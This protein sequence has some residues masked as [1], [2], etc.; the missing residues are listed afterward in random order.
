MKNL[1]R[2]YRKSALRGGTSIAV[3][4]SLATASV[5]AQ[6]QEQDQESS[7][8]SDQVIVLDQIVVSA[9]RVSE[10]LQEVPLAITALSGDD[11][12]RQQVNDIRDLQGLV[13]NLHL[14]NTA[15]T[16][17]AAA[18]FIR[19]IGQP[20]Q[21]YSFDPGVAVYVDE[22]YSA[23]LQLGLVQAL[24]IERVEVLRGPQGTLYGKNTTGGAIKFYTRQPSDSLEGSTS[25]SAGNYDRLDL[26]GML[27]VPLGEGAAL[28]A[29][30][31]Y[32]RRDGYYF[33]RFSNE[34]SGGI[35]SF[36]GRAALSFQPTENLDVNL[37]LDHTRDRSESVFGT[38]LLS[39]PPFPTL[40]P[41]EADA[42]HPSLNSQ[43]ST[44]VSAT[45]TLALNAVTLKS[46]SGYRQLE[47]AQN[48]DLDG[49][50]IAILE[51][52]QRQKS[53]QFSQELQA[54]FDIGDRGNAILGAYYFRERSQQTTDTFG[55]V[56]HNSTDQTT[57]SL[58]AFVNVKYALT[59]QLT[60]SGGIRF[61]EESKDWVNDLPPYLNQ[62]HT[63][64]SWTNW[65]SRFALDYQFSPD[66]LGYVSYADGFKAGGFNPQ[67]IGGSAQR[68][69]YDPE[70]VRSYELG[71]KSQP[72]PWLTINTALFYNDFEDYQALVT[73]IDPFFSEL[74]GGIPI[75]TTTNA[76][77]FESHGAEIEVYARPSQ[78]LTLSGNLAYFE[79]SYSDFNDPGTGADLSSN[80]LPNAPRWQS[81]L[82][83]E[84][85][86]PVGNDA[87]IRFGGTVAYRSNYYLSV[88]NDSL[89]NQDGYARV[90]AHI[91]FDLNDAVTFT[92]AGRNLTE[93]A[94]LVDA[95][96]L[97]PLYVTGYYGE[98]RVVSISA[99]A[100][101]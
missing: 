8:T 78:R 97:R 9:R 79:N 3:M 74:L 41:F 60:A 59:D 70:T 7:A 42:N 46:I 15:G 4:L 71:I 100:R 30:A 68:P 25:I 24:D 86:L 85:T 39:F 38:P 87:R 5:F 28:R 27:N 29:N 57:E 69:S 34:D 61:S 83:A 40:P 58:A 37:S 75:G 44:G 2:G 96:G 16:N 22:V 93:E 49:F 45:A 88:I 77:G 1:D 64:D 13:P 90:D 43:D 52:E 81:G 17:N 35:D 62:F 63:S 95:F 23:R 54:L 55:Q 48:L 21:L 80:K 20:N 98:P 6:E 50:P 92:L 33:N 73:V 36:T 31:F 18:V 32:T 65:T 12:E 101:F 91:A 89:M 66:V 72:A 10:S 56:T 11:L 94:Y 82:N 67:Y 99:T 76:G 84:Y 19:G 53:E 26:R 47:F 14:Y 51:S